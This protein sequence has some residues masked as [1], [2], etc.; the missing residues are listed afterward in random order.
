MTPEIAQLT[1]ERCQR[2]TLPGAA[3]CRAVAATK[4][5][6]VRPAHLRRFDRDTTIFEEGQERGVVGVVRSGYLRKER[7]SRDGRRTLL[8]LACPGDT[9]GALP[10]RSIAYSLEAATDAEICA[11]DN[12]TMQRMVA[13]DTDFR[14]HLLQQAAEQHATLLEMIWWRGALTTRERII[15]FLLMA[16]EVMPVVPQPDG[17]IIVTIE[18]ARRDWADLSNTT[19][20]SISRTMRHLSEKDLVKT[21]APGRFRIRNLDSL[22]SLAGMDNGRTPPERGSSHQ[23]ERAA[24]AFSHSD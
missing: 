19:V 10:G 15:A 4:G 17:S 18:L 5:V 21:V 13:Q 12:A 1:P 3:L 14:L 20:E 6:G 8:G 23:P 24:S 2:C 16:A 22:A 11:F 9:I 7:M